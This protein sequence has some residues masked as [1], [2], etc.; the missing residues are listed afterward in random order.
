M[1]YDAY[2][3]SAG[4]PIGRRPSP[5]LLS[6]KS[7]H[8]SMVRG[9]VPKPA[10]QPGGAQPGGDALRR[11]ART[12]RHRSVAG[13]R[14]ERLRSRQGEAWLTAAEAQV[15][16]ARIDML[17]AVLR[18]LTDQVRGMQSSSWRGQGQSAVSG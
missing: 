10:H 9:E 11:D 5:T 16:E 17:E 4:T 15:I 8:R 7:F 2:L 1:G 6:G 3:T 14:D 12:T 18:D 13:L